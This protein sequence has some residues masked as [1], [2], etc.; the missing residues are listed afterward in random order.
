MEEN[1][2]KKVLALVLA[3][4]MLTSLAFATVVTPGEKIKLGKDA[5]VWDDAPE[6]K[7]NSDNYSISKIDWE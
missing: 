7:V 6:K 2:M 5:A 4:M 1:T 3:V